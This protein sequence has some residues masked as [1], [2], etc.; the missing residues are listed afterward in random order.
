MMMFNRCRERGRE[1]EKERARHSA[2]RSRCPSPDSSAACIES[3]EEIRYG[4]T[5]IYRIWRRYGPTHI[6]RIWR[7]DP[8]R[9]NT[10]LCVLIR[11]G[12]THIYRIWRRYG[13]THFNILHH[14]ATHWKC[15]SSDLKWIKP[16]VNVIFFYFVCLP[17]FLESFLIQRDVMRCC[18]CVHV[19][20]FVNVHVHSNVQTCTHAF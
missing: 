18:E 12:S 15:P 20:V 10:H 14:A 4:S 6:Y 8:I 17:N 3:G 16:L 9:I 7:R 13:S 11:Y 2:T 1:R 5:H 19:Y